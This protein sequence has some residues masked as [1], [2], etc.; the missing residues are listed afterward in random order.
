MSANKIVL[1]VFELLSKKI[2]S[3]TCSSIK[4]MSCTLPELTK[5]DIGI[6]LMSV[7][8]EIL[9]HFLFLKNLFL[10]TLIFPNLFKMKEES[11]SLIPTEDFLEKELRKD[12]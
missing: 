6:P 5:T 2:K 10:P 3:F 8:I 9:V 4:V 7:T 12:K 11:T 1:F